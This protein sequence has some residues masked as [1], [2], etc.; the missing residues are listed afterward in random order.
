VSGGPSP[1]TNTSLHFETN[2]RSP[3]SKTA[4]STAL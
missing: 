3:S 1:D 2:S 4:M